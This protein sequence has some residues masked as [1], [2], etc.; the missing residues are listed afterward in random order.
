MTDNYI[1]STIWYCKISK[2]NISIKQLCKV[3]KD[4]MNVFNKLKYNLT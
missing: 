4:L 2:I 3:C 1:N